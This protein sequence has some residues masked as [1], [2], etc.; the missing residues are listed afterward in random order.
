MRKILHKIY[1]SLFPVP[2]N[3]LKAEI[4]LTS[5]SS[6]LEDRKIAIIGGTRGIGRAMAEKF[7]AEGAKVVITGRSKDKAVNAA[8]EIGCSSYALDISNCD[9]FNPF[10]A[11]CV[12]ALGALDTLVI[13]AGISLHEGDIINVTPQQFDSQIAT[14]LRGAYFAAQAF[15]KY[16]MRGNLRSTNL[17]FIS[18]ERGEYVDML[19]YGLTK[20][21]MNSLVCGLAKRC[22]K[23]DMRVNAV[24]PGV[25]ATDLTSYDANSNLY[26]GDQMNNRIY[27][28]QEMAEVANFL[29]SNVSN[30]LTGQIIVCN[31]G[32][33]I[34]SYF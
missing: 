1:R 16:V 32:K 3:N 12:E 27:L 14:N 15:I 22:I 24:A 6:L 29:V 18:S 26:R 21:A 5:P 31:E 2:V 34:N 10:I 9:D 4:A 7:V 33:S 13:N 25:T 8:N 23:L 30:C 11:Q 28:P 19:P 20:A 17:L